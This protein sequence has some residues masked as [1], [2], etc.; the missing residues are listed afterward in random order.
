MP[1]E[2]HKMQN[3]IEE[4]LRFNKEL[5]RKMQF[6]EEKINQIDDKHGQ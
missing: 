3:Q 1:Q 4:L 5:E 6:T 2:I